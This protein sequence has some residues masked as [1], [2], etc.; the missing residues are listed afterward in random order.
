MNGSNSAY[1]RFA[2]HANS[3]WPVIIGFL[4]GFAEGTVFFI[5][6]DVYLGLVALFNW[7]RGLWAMVAAVIGALFGG[8]VM[9]ELAMRDLSGVNSFLTRIP[10]INAEMI[11][12]IANK[13]QVDGLITM[14]NGPL[15]GVPYKIYAVQAGGQSLPFLTFLLMTILARLER[16][17][18][19]TLLAGGLGKWS[20][21]FI[22]KHTTL[23][24][25]IYVLIWG[26]IYF[27]YYLRF[28]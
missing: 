9:Y 17:M 7:R 13:M 8:S 28:H 22:E 16:L 25:G 27:L 26:I 20:K 23:V 12:D 19:V 4:W 3:K 15:R 1:A 5:V 21:G 2:A 24:V 11:A 6:P 10:L 14:I 18:P